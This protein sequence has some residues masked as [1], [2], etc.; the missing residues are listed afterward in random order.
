MDRLLQLVLPF[1][2]VLLML[3]FFKVPLVLAF[4][5]ILLVLAHLVSVDLQVHPPSVHRGQHRPQ[6]SLLPLPAKSI[7]QSISLQD[8]N[9]KKALAQIPNTNV[10]CKR[11]FTADQG[12]SYISLSSWLCTRSLSLILNTKY[13]IPNTEY[14]I[15]N[16]K[17]KTPN[18]KSQI[19][20]IP[21]CPPLLEIA[22][23]CLTQVLYKLLWLLNH[24]HASGNQHWKN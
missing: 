18:T 5:K 24:L 8:G 19:P 17:Y 1:L 9:V 15:P 11:V 13:I 16:T 6:K 2:K 22:A 12:E 4:L 23:P 21:V 7:I 14:Q 20:N 3:A 10:K